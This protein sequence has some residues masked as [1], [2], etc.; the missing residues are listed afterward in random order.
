MDAQMP[1]MDG[2]EAT[3]QIKARWPEVRVVVVTM[4]ASYRAEAQAAGADGFL[5]KGDPVEEFLSAILDDRSASDQNAMEPKRR[6]SR[7]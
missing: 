4:Y 7:T 6:E 5:Q 2:L 1:Q 3:R